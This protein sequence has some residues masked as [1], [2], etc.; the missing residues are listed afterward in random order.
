MG[1]KKNREKE[2]SRKIWRKGVSKKK[3]KIEC[4]R[5]ENE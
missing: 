1:E 5:E 4:K 2:R 3:K